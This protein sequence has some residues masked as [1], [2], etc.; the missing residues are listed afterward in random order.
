MSNESNQPAEVV[1]QFFKDPAVA[2]NIA[3]LVTGAKPA[4]FGPRSNS[5]YFKELYGQV[6]KEAADVMI[7][8]REDCMYYYSQFPN[9]SD[10]TVYAMVNQSM[11]FLVERMDDETFKYAK[12]ANV[13]NVTKERGVGV[14]IS[15]IE[16]YRNASSMAHVRPKSVLGKAQAPAWKQEVDTYCADDRMTKPLEIKGLCLTPDEIKMMRDSLARIAVISEVTAQSIVIIKT[17][18]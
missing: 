10:G 8:T 1:K 13:I 15:F 6:M 17:T 11:R 12:W 14:R 2:A 16:D 4:T 7:E 9:I 5:P 3:R 18:A